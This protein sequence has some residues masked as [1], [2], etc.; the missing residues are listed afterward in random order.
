MS[1]NF[2]KIKPWS[3]M[4]RCNLADDE[5]S[6]SAYFGDSWYNEDGYK[7]D[8]TTPVQVY[9][10]IPMFYYRR[11]KDIPASEMGN[12]ISYRPKPGFKLHPTFDR[13]DGIKTKIYV[14]SF[15]ASFYDVS[16]D[17]YSD[18]YKGY[19]TPN[20]D[21][22]GDFDR[23]TPVV[24]VVAED[25]INTVAGKIRA[26]TSQFPNWT[27]SGTDADVIFTCKTAGAKTTPS[28]STAQ[29]V[30][31][32]WATTVAGDDT[33]EAVYTLTIT[34]AATTS[35]NITVNIDGFTGF[36]PDPTATTGDLLSSVAGYFPLSKLT[37]A[38]FR[39]M[40]RNRG[41]KFSLVDYS[42]WTAIQLLQM[43]ELG[44][45]DG[46]TALGMGVVNKTGATY[47]KA[48][49]TG[50]TAYTLESPNYGEALGLHHMMYR[51]IEDLWGNVWQWIDGIN[52]NFITVSATADTPIPYWCND[53]TL[54][55][56]DTTS[57][58][59]DMGI[60]LSSHPLSG[61]GYIKNIHATPDWSFL[62]SEHQSSAGYFRDYWYPSSTAGWRVLRGG[63][64][65]TYGGFLGPW[66]IYA[67]S[68]S[69]SAGLIY[70]GRLLRV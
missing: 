50:T 58:Y 32:S 39:Q 29:G 44:S 42:T 51:G 59:E 43:I 65:W 46:Q 63:G 11:Y 18:Y 6:P 13:P 54:Y 31:S 48:E 16:R 70:G 27:L 20:T 40:A 47:Y 45:L 56:D 5:N 2:N 1:I 55:S 12:A 67:Y 28:L 66:A 60:V 41:A 52:I 21:D 62:P 23:A 22:A 35:G 9:T 25:S 19:A 15:L 30:T 69:A 8:G 24:A 36:A 57:N 14:G 17:E 4:L 37:R 53:I 34:G 64:P 7:D 49:A 38:Q 68:S 33:T 61:N 10:Q 26:A 3:E